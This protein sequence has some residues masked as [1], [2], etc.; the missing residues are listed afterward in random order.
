MD[1][2]ALTPRYRNDL[3]GIWQVMVEEASESEGLRLKSLTMFPTK[4]DRFMARRLAPDED[5]SRWV[6]GKI[7]ELSAE[8]GT[9]ASRISDHKGQLVFDLTV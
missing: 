6:R 9:S 8:L 7:T 1:D 5:D 3:S 2:Y 4:I